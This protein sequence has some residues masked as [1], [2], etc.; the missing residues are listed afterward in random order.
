MLPEWEDVRKLAYK[1]AGRFSGYA[2]LDDLIQE[3][4]LCYA[5]ACKDYDPEQGASFA[6]YFAQ[7]LHWHLAEYTARS[8]GA[9][10]PINLFWK[11]LQYR[12]Y[13]SRYQQA[14]GREPTASEIA[15]HFRITLQ[16][17]RGLSDLSKKIRLRSLSEPIAGE[18]EDITLQDTL[19][20][21]DD[22]FQSVLDAVAD[23][24]LSKELDTIIADLPELE[25]EAVR[26]KY[27]EGLTYQEIADQKHWTFSTVKSRCA[28]GLQKLRTGKYYKRIRK[29][30]SDDDRYSQGL[31]PGYSTEREALWII[32]HEYEGRQ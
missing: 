4:Y 12:R 20:S 26:L 9:Y 17:V 8:N 10:I 7:R 32:E 2:E 1:I 21:E 3:S 27:S 24:Q 6:H 28:A 30:V 15:D 18:D 16:E 19:Q 11:V 23:E 14:H 5:D 25:A 22:A 13:I 31:R 29:A